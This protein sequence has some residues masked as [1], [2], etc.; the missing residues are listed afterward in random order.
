MSYLSRGVH[1]E[2]VRILQEKLG[3]T[4][5]GIFGLATEEALKG[6][7]SGNGLAA[8]GIAGPDTFMS[9]GLHELL[10]LSKGTHGEAVKKLQEGLGIAADGKFGPGTDAAV[11]KFQQ[12]KGLDV[13]GIA[14]PL[15]LAQVPG[16]EEITV[17]KV[18]AS[19][20][21]DT[22][23]EVDPAAVQAVAA[24]EPPPPQG[25]IAK[26]EDKVA[27]VGKSIWNTVKKIF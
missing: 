25:V 24:A 21:K 22:T 10:L 27:S 7:Q 9:M 20:V 8:D 23:P 6:Y 3:V 2:P 17:E 16:F 12:E 18:E 4:A 15:T 5:D 19:L 26:V 1:G 13:D 11:R 14:G